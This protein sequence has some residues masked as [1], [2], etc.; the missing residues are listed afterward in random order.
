MNSVDEYIL[1]GAAIISAQKL[2]FALYGIVSHLSHLPEARKE[3]RFRE[4]TP[5]EFLRGDMEDLKATLGQISTAFGDTLLMS[6]EELNQFIKDR[7]LIAH[8][9]WRLTKTSIRNADKLNDP[10]AFLKK[11][12]TNSD[13]WTAIVRGLLYKL[14]EAAA[15]KEGRTSEISFNEQQIADIA[16]YSAHASAILRMRS[17]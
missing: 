13:Q 5:E 15:E 9:Y 17:S 3:K 6:N 10:E 2:E 1:L 12:I 7:N 14:M 4:L 11:F 8:N 16:T